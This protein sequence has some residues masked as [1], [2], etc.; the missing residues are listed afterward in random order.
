MQ[1]F[2]FYTKIVLNR[3]IKIMPCNECENGKWRW[4][5]SGEC[6]YNSLEA[7]EEA[8]VDYYA[9]SKLNQKGY[10]KAKSL[11]EEDK[12]DINSD[13]SFSS[14]D[15]N[16]LLGEDGEDWDNYAKWFLLINEDAAEETKDRYK[17]PFGKNDKVYRKGLTAIRQRAG[18][19]GY[20]DVF[21]AAGKL[22][23]MIDKK[24]E[25]GAKAAPKK[26]KIRYE[27][28]DWKYSFSEEQMEELH[29]EGE[30]MVKVAKEDKEMK[31]LFTYDNPMAHA[32]KSEDELIMAML[33]D[34]LDEYIDKLTDSIK[35][36]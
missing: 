3:K 1:D 8:N 26:K 30:L 18:Q 7:C 17:F 23:E 6:Q 29:S 34:E 11:I 10:S 9:A 36:L 25:G 28:Y 22:I 12:V 2:G 32:T 15:G 5:D 13:W 27:E 24:E 35:Q 31:I 16:K 21:E 14:E 20:T 4:G 19:F 33:D